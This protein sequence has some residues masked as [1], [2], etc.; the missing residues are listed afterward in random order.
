M[1]RWIA[2]L[3]MLYPRSWRDEFGEEFGALLYDVKP[4]WRVFR[5][6]LGGAI[7]MQITEGTNWMRVV[8]ATAVCG[9]LVAGGLSYRVAPN[10]VSSAVI[11]VTPQADPVRPTSPE[12]LHQ[13]AAADIALMEAEILS[14]TDLATIISDPRL[15][16]YREEL[17]RMPFE[18]VIQE[19]RRNI[20]IQ[21][22]P[23]ADGGMAPIVFSISFSYPD[24]AK[25]QATVRRLAGKF[26]EENANV[27]RERVESYQ[28]FWED[29]ARF[30]HTNPAPPAPV[31][32][33]VGVL[34]TASLPMDSVGPNRLAFLAWG[35]GVGL[36]VGLLVAAGMRRPRGVWQ[37]GGFA[38]AGFAVACALSYLIPNRFTSTASMEIAPA[39]LTED[40]L[41]PLPAATTAAEY[42]RQVEPEVLSYQSLSKIIQNP[43][44]NLYSEERAK[45]PMD[46]VVRNMLA[47]DLRI[48]PVEGSASAFSIS[49]SYSDMYNAQRTVNAL[50][51][52]FEEQRQNEAYA[53]VP[54]MSV[55]V[56]W[57][58]ERKGGE[59]LE[60]LDSASLAVTPV[61]PNRAAI[62]L[63]GMGVGLLI[64]VVMVWRRRVRGVDAT[65][66][67]C[68]VN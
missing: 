4:S 55:A 43:R 11:S 38:L 41:E 21:A 9:A 17:R 33:I 3:A 35:L 31:G 14:R 49:F 47:N 23:S 19:M 44:L 30:A 64:G 46:E 57:I 37:L 56:H 7:S 39:M 42:L 58:Y 61:A 50:M 52:A 51:N 2:F 26:T 5:N 45:K 29:M 13:R 15:L 16:L 1:R 63:A 40:P 59:V 36:A 27:N 34:N 12:A 62:S 22:L 48:S 10:Y 54:Q 32:E 20:H 24:Q 68:P 65:I 25:A 53:K 18:D 66:V 28:G 8:A 60:V 67:A 6:V